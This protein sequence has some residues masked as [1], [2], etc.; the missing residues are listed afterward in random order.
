MR[1]FIAEKPEIANAIADA[2]GGQWADKGGYKEKGDDVITWCYGHM[3]A[4]KEPEDYDHKKFARWSFEQLPYCVLPA[5]RKLKGG[6]FDKQTRIIRDLLK[7]ADTV[8]NAG[9]TDEEG[10]LLI[11]ELLRYYNY[12]KPVMRIWFSVNNKKIVTKALQNIKSNKE[13]EHLGFK[14]EARAIADQLFGVNLS[15]AYT[16]AAGGYTTLTVGRVQSPILGMVVRRDRENASHTKSYY[17][18]IEADLVVNGMSFKARYRPTAN[19]SVDDTRRLDDESQAL[20]IVKACQGK[21]VT[22]LKAV[23]AKKSTPPPLPYNINKLQQDASTL[24]GFRPDKTLKITQDLRE[25]HRAITYN[26]SDCQYL[27][28]EQFE[29]AAGTLSAM[30][31]CPVVASLAANADASIKGRVFDSSKVSAHHAIVPTDEQIDWQSF[32]GDEKK[33]YELIAKLYAIQFYP[34][35]L[36]DETKLE[37]GIDG[38]TFY[39]TARVDTD[40]GYKKVWGSNSSSD[41]EGEDT[42]DSENAGSV[43]ADLRSLTDGMKGSCTDCQIQKKETKPLPLYTMKS[44]LNDLTRAAKYVKNKSLAAK[45]KEKDKDKKGESGGIGTSATRSAIIGNLLDRGFIAEKGKNVVSTDLGQKF[46]DTLDDIIKYPDMSAIWYEQQ[47]QI[48]SL[49]DVEVFIINMMKQ[50]VE[51]EIERLKSVQLQVAQ[52]YP[53]PVCTR[54][55]V[56][57]K[58]SHG[59]FWGCTGHSDKDNPCNNNMPDKGGKPA[60]K[61]PKKEVILSEFNCKSCGKPLILRSG[62]LKSGKNKGKS[63]KF[64]GCSGFPKCE[65]KYN[66]VDGVPKYE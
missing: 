7:K 46:Y 25:K 54:P 6:S 18:T 34:P 19:D 32:S 21:T 36:Y 37:V 58:S 59:Y 15:R 11:D 57:L 42:E 13:Y 47:K 30:A 44:L 51:P 22:I 50:V 60:P 26:R 27:S 23:T 33:M 41:D 63:Y 64:F 62:V 4:L 20:S 24:Y 5:Q 3:L 17:Y 43:S 28:D 9:D 48:E 8:V 45:L 2:I 29:D 65:Q 55:M 49:D 14:A 52:T 56:R 53:C 39:V 35:N 1:L 61:E 10:Q 31:N 12:T 16:L 40:L 66:E 38:F